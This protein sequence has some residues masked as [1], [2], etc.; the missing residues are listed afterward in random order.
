MWQRGL[1]KINTSPFSAQQS[2]IF[3]TL[4]QAEGDVCTKSIKL[5]YCQELTKLFG[6][7]L[8]EVRGQG[9]AFRQDY[10]PTPWSPKTD[11][12]QQQICTD[13]EQANY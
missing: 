7:C 6:N 2:P 9:D 12:Y 1:R 8:G 10:L 4:L 3:G 5:S 11:G 13:R